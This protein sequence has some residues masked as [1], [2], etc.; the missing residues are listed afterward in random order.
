M[1]WNCGNGWRSSWRISGASHKPPH[2]SALPSC[3][4]RQPELSIPTLLLIAISRQLLIFIDSYVPAI[5]R[6]CL[7]C[8]VK[9]RRNEERIN[10]TTEAPLMLADQ[11]NPVNYLNLLPFPSPSSLVQLAHGNRTS[12]NP[13]YIN[14]KS[15]LAAA[16]RLTCL[17]K[18]EVLVYVA[19]IYLALI[20]LTKCLAGCW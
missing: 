18:E 4:R 12:R 2:P 8:R 5:R 20:L 10:Q 16:A 7:C 19:P 3:S 1:R 6:D 11:V 17:S 9:V 13:L 14:L 15:F